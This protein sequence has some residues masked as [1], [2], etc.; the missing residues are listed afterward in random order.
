MSDDGELFAAWSAG[1]REAGAQLFDRHF[2]ALYRFF[3]NKVRTGADDLVQATFLACVEAPQAFR[4]EGSFRGFLFGV[5]RNLLGKHYR[6]LLRR[7]GRVDPGVTS[8]HDLAPG[9]SEVVAERAEQRLLLAALRRLPLDAQLVLELYFW[10][11]MTAPE[12]AAVLVVPEGTVRTRLRRA[13]QLLTARLAELASSREL[14]HSTL[15]DLEGWARSLREQ[16][17]TPGPAR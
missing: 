8:L 15:T 16:L 4:R 10:E 17:S 6:T 7:D 1:D 12:A 3:R 13:K 11:S 14:L 2:A 9:P 5:A